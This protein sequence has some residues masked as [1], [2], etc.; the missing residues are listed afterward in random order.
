MLAAFNAWQPG[1]MALSAW[2]LV[3]A[4]PLALS[5]VGELARDGDTRWI[6]RGAHDL[7]GA[8]EGVRV[9]PSGIPVARSLY[10]SLVEQSADPDS[11]LA[12]L[13]SVLRVRQNLG[14]ATATPAGVA[15]CGHP[16]VLG[17]QHVLYD[18]DIQLT[19]LN[20]SDVPVTCRLSTDALVPGYE[21]RDV[22]AGSAVGQVDAERGFVLTLT[23]YD[24]RALR[25]EPAG[26]PPVV[27]ATVPE[28]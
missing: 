24:Y 1:V 13:T 14:L 16:A 10:G 17:L 19:V 2:D 12:G 5:D 27:P 11:F 15:D 28:V 20:F 21:V 23:P 8:A 7:M 4:L 3:G 18:T 25:V 26:H 6:N 9:A 22:V